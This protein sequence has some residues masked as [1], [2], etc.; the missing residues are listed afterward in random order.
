MESEV[1]VL[2]LAGGKGER[3]WPRSSKEKPKQLQEIY[4]EKTLLAETLERARLLTKKERIFIGCD[5]H[6]RNLILEKHTE[7]SKEAFIIE[8]EGRN[9]APMI[10]LAS[11]ELEQRFPGAVHVIMPADHYIH[12]PEKFARTLEKAIQTAQKNF[13]VTLGIVP[14]SPETQYGYIQAG[15]ALEKEAKEKAFAAKNILSFTEK[16]DKDTAEK[17]LAQGNY[18]WNSGIFIWRGKV[19][20]GEFQKHAP[21]IINPLKDFFRNAEN[22]KNE[23]ALG[24]SFKKLPKLP[25]DIAIME[26]SSNAVVIPADFHWDDLGS[27]TSLERVLPADREGNIFFQRK[28]KEA[29]FSSLESSNNIL[30]VDDGLIAL[31]GVKDLVIVREGEVLF[32]AQREALDRVKEFLEKMR[33]NPSLQKYVS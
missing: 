12:P 26:K 11:L 6:F 13:L 4:S 3:F 7:L 8:A 2:I 23:G 25:I 28:E 1:I 9:T 22:S 31:L 10:A 19:I 18:F 16:P 33:K 32:V 15:K 14:K 30:A 21:E 27:W 17:Y 29:D 5:S 24:L 20:L